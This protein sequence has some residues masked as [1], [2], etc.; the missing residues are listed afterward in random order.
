MNRAGGVTGVL[1]RSV[2]ARRA[3]MQCKTTKAEREEARGKGLRQT[4]I[5]DMRDAG[6]RRRLIDLFGGLG[7]RVRV[8]SGSAEGLARV[9]REVDARLVLVEVDAGASEREGDDRVGGVLAMARSV[10]RAPIVAAARAPTAGEVVHAVKLG[11]SDFLVLDVD[12]DEL[13]AAVA[14]M[15][16]AH[17]EPATPAGDSPIETRV[18]GRSRAARLMRSRLHGLASLAGP[19]LVIGEAG[20]GRDTVARALHEAGAQAGGPFRRVDCAVWRPGEELPRA[21]TLYLDHVDRLSAAGQQFF[22]HRLRQMEREGWERGPRIVASAGPGFVAGRTDAVRNGADAFDRTLFDELMRF[23]LELV[24]LRER[25]E[26]VPEIADRIVD[27]LGE[28][29]RREVR[30]TPDAHA[31]LARQGWPGN[32]QQLAR[33]LERG[34]AFCA[35]GRIDGAAIE[36]LVDDF[37]ES[38]AAI[39]RKRAADERDELLAT[40]AR[41]G[42]NI[43]RCAEEMGRSRGAVY[44]LID[45]YGIA[46]PKTMRK[47]SPP[48]SAK[49]EATG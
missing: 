12:D 41:T 30:L 49:V 4:V 48:A 16:E 34:V 29:M 47:R 7:W 21:G 27:R 43:S 44:R 40:L 31:F 5:L 37:E 3:E 28:R 46:L 38:L 10:T 33:V 13:R 25:L 15:V 2:R 20:S 22:A 8:T 17:A 11:A 36:Q 39:R 6:A 23:P 1:L 32:V 35:G 19:V 24:P 18:V 42:G 14:R 45:K 9:C 26:D